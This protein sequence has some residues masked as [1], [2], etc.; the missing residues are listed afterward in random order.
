[1]KTRIISIMAIVMLTATMAFSQGTG[2][3]FGV[4]GGVNFQNL[5]GTDFSGDKLENDMIIGFHAGVNVQIP[6]APEFYFQPG[7]LFSTK[8]AKNTID[9]LGTAFTTTVKLS[10]VEL[11]LNL[12]YKGALGN[13]FVL[14][15]FGPYVGYGI[16]GKEI[17]E[18]GPATIEREVKFQNIVETGDPASVHYVK[19]LDAGANV[20]AG[21][22]M[23]GGLFMQLNAQLGLIKIN[24][25]DKR[26]IDDKTS[27]KNTGF[28][29]SLGYRL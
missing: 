24:P 9:V 6:V 12:V 15:G 13:G 19:A 1:M 26:L 3:R 25:E 10:Y 18:G 21:Y 22:E 20:F 4:L 27:V 28:G 8:G 5:N 23:A 17:N 29:L 14:V 16:S 11:P 2:M 7:L